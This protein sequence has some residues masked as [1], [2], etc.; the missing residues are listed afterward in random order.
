MRT[1]RSALLAG[2]LGFAVTFITACGGG[3]GLLS[4]SQADNLNNQLDQVSS[5]L[6]SGDCNGVRTATRSLV[7]AVATL[8]D[9]VNLTLREDLGHAASQVSTLAVQQCHPAASTTSPITTATT[10]TAPTTTATTRTNTTTTTTPTT[11]TPTTPTTPATTPT[12][13][14]TNTGPSGGGGLSGGSSGTGGATGGASGG[15]NGNGNGNG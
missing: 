4:G 10:S 11:T 2:G 5:T 1:L 3:A 8:P 13:P 6:S 7:S 9:S 12:T 15:S 14:G